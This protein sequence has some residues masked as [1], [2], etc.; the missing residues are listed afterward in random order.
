M[1]MAW[2]Q[3]HRMVGMRTQVGDTGQRAVTTPARFDYTSETE[4]R[5][6]WIRQ[7]EL[8]RKEGLPEECGQNGEAKPGALEA[9]R[10]VWQ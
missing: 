7:S 1:G 8:W 9:E 2:E 5:V 3:V 10:I 4:G 6:H